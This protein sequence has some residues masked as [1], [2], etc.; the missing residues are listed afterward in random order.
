MKIL[1]VFIKNIHSLKGEQEVNF[2]EGILADA[3]L[4]AITG[5]T[6]AGKSTI[7]DAITL[8]LYG[9][10]NRHGKGKAEEIITR[11]EREAIAETTFEVNHLQYLARWSVAYNRNN[12]LNDWELKFF[13]KIGKDDFQLIADKKSIA[14]TEIQKV[15]GLTFEQFTKSVLLAQNNFAAFLKAKPAE[16]AEMLSKITGTEIYETISKTVFEKTKALEDEIEAQK[17]GLNN[18]LLSQEELGILNHNLTTNQAEFLTIQKDLELVSKSITW[19]E[20]K[21]KAIV[22]LSNYTQSETEVLTQIANND[23]LYKKLAKFKKAQLI[24]KELQAYENAL[25]LFEKN[26]TDLAA[27]Q[28]K[29]IENKN[30]LQAVSDLFSEKNNQSK[31]VKTELET[32]LPN[33]NLAKEKVIEKQNI[34]QQLNQITSEINEQNQI[35]NQLTVNKNKLNDVSLNLNNSL[36]EK[37]NIVRSLAV[38]ANWK[39]DS[40]AVKT[41]YNIVQNAE[42]FLAEQQVDGIKQA[43]DLQQKDIEKDND[44]LK[45]LANELAAL[46]VK[47]AEY[48]TQQTAL[49]PNAELLLDKD[50]AK[51]NLQH[52]QTLES[53]EKQHTEFTQKVNISKSDFEKIS[54]EEEQLTNTIIGLLK[55]QKLLEDKWRL[56][57]KVSVL[58]EHRAGLED[59]KPCPL[60]GALKHPLVTENTELNTDET[61]QQLDNISAEIRSKNDA[62]I[63]LNALKIQHQTSWK[64]SE[65]SLMKI[66]N[67][68]KAIKEVFNADFT[69]NNFTENKANLEAVLLLIE[70]D[71]AKNEQLDLALKAAIE[72]LQ[73]SNQKFQEIKLGIVKKEGE[74]TN[75]NQQ[76]ATV[77]Q[78]IA[79][80][81]DSINS[82]Y[83]E[84]SLIFEK[85]GQKLEVSALTA[86]LKLAT[87]INNNNNL[88]EDTTIEI[89]KIKEE[90]NNVNTEL[91]SINASLVNTKNRVEEAIKKQTILNENLVLLSESIEKLTFDF[92]N[93]N[94]ADEELRLRNRFQHLD[95]ETNQ[96]IQQKTVLE[97]E[98]SNQNNVIDTL[99]NE[100]VVLNQNCVD[101]EVKLIQKLHENAFES[102][103][104]LKEA[105]NLPQAETI[106]AQQ[107]ELANKL[108][109]VQTLLQSTYQKLTILN[110]ENITEKDLT[111]LQLEKVH[112]TQKSTFINQEIGGINEKIEKDKAE[113]SNNEKKLLAIANKQKVFEKWEQLNKLIGSKTGDS[114]KKF[115]Q[116]F[117]LSL[118]VQ[119][120]NKHL[121]IMYNRYE[122]FKD[123]TSAEMELQIKDKH[124][125]EEV[126]S[127]NSLSG[128][129]TFLVSLA[130]A[131]GLSDLASKNTKIRSLFID[132][133]FGT[134]DPESLNNAL[135]ALELLRQ[136]D[137][138]QI[139]I[140]SHVEELKKRIHTQI[141]V[142]KTSA[143]FS[144]IL[145]TDE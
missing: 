51:Q 24:E 114:F 35:L 50:K 133:G 102:I 128:G 68:I 121:E 12:K 100:Q 138:R 28:N 130:L 110:A 1:K 111:A 63:A 65:E 78:Q 108:L 124:F 41:S 127:L 106:A 27:A 18:N 118:L 103:E 40:G 57:L 137:D 37:E 23:L 66:T 74:L 144:K 115:A 82:A 42:K 122:L 15:I 52:F 134:L 60:C 125:F 75:K 30:N 55:T 14:L 119:Y 89:G 132:E 54:I 126:R 87:A 136:T 61:K 29:F 38:Y 72:I 17:A 97:T 107:Q 95:S 77:N 25:Q 48:K 141:K 11:K 94:P 46:N 99:Q 64:F 88:Y 140:I 9:E 104:V 56:Q 85:Y 86:V 36:L 76:L 8:A 34:T 131:I 58:E 39:A 13:K 6:G 81:Q 45:Q 71:L 83:S 91:A 79:E 123:D 145:V 135:D 93:K 116:D 84:L 3:G 20:E 70:Q 33:I 16:R 142:T 69:S 96:L 49:K 101:L 21:Q 47:I 32:K 26:K 5:Q 98:I 22:D 31:V 120:A 90:L 73:I 129:E 59:G 10:T 19:L 113:K 4:Y 112:L 80:K 53:L 143:E 139:G 117:T 92:E 43:I 2:N 44:L 62:K 109:A 67:E 105:L 7:L